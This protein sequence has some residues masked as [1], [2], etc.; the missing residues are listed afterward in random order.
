M[1]RRTYYQTLGLSPGCDPQAVEK[2]F[3]RCARQWHPDVNPSPEAL[4][5]FC[6]LQRAYQALSNPKARQGYDLLLAS[7]QF[8]AMRRPLPV[9]MS[10]R[11]RHRRGVR[12]GLVLMLTL[13][14]GLI[15]YTAYAVATLWGVTVPF[16]ANQGAANSSPASTE[17]LAE[18]DFVPSPR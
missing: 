11:R 8:R 17:T 18:T 3:R 9:M 2:A 6:E 14:V 15:G 4:E 13:N 10:R 5:R 1:S 12:W 7:Q 16:V